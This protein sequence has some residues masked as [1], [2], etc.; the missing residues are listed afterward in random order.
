RG[1]KITKKLVTILRSFFEFL[2]DRAIKANITAIVA[3]V[4]TIYTQGFI[5]KEIILISD[6]K[7]KAN[8]KQNIKY[9]KNLKNL[10]FE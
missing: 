9:V 8:D 6:R 5:S 2:K 4:T 10:F 3:R 7:K 1:K